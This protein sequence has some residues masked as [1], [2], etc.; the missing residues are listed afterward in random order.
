[1]NPEWVN[2]DNTNLSVYPL[3]MSLQLKKS[4]KHMQ[5][6]NQMFAKSMYMFYKSH[7]TFYFGSI[8]ALDMVEYF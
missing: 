7:K 1:M 3:I 6:C 5:R 8:H 2:P 4:I